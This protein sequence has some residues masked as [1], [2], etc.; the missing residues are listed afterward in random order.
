V[1]ATY[2]DHEPKLALSCANDWQLCKDNLDLMK[3]YGGMSAAH[4][5]CAA[6]LNRAANHREA[7]LP[8]QAFETFHDGDHYVQSGVV[9]LIEPH[10]IYPDGQGQMRP[11]TVTCMFDL[12]RRKVTNLII[13]A[14]D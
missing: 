8:L 4:A 12:A 11:K 14:A 7:K 1:L 2:S 10:A 5:A 13:V 6:T 3:H 9:T